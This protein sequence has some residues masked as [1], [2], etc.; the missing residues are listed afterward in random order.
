MEYQSLYRKYRPKNFDSV[1]GQEVVLKILKNAIDQSKISHAYLF[2]G[3]RGTG[4]TT[5]ARILA[6]AIN[7][8]F[9]NNGNCCEKCKPCEIAN[10]KEN[11]DILEIDAASNNGVNEIRELR[12]KINLVPNTLKYKVYII[13]EVHMLSREAFP[14]L[15]KTL[16]E[17]PKHAIFILATTELHEVPST[18]LSR[19]QLLEFKQ[20]SN[21]NLKKRLLEISTGEDINI[22][23]EALDEICKIVNGG[24]R[25][26]IGILEKA[27]LYA[28]DSITAEDI[29]KINGNI[30]ENSVK[31]LVNFINEENI[32]ALIN[33]VDE[34]HNSGIDLI[35][36]ANEIIHY[37]RDEI[38]KRKNTESNIL[39]NNIEELNDSINKMR[40]ST[41]PKPIFEIT[42][43]KLCGRNK[44][45]TEH[46]EE[47]T[48]ELPPIQPKKEYPQKND[49]HK[50]EEFKQID[51]PD[52]YKD[53]K[54][55]RVNNTLSAADKNIITE[56]REKWQL[57]RNEAFNTTYGAFARI[58][59]DDAKP[60]AASNEYLI[61]TFKIESLATQCNDAM[62][63]IE[64]LIQNILKA[65]YRIICLSDEEW[66]SCIE[67]YKQNK[68]KY[69]YIKE[70]T[71]D[72]TI[73]IEAPETEKNQEKTLKDKA[74]ELFGEI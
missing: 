6:K 7:C 46:Q 44:K 49:E 10:Q 32:E 25:D 37:I 67:D 53:I 33:K 72:K 34:Y 3:P 23:E 51:Q 73:D 68:E 45:I 2:A 29:R 70:E 28:N 1:V 26:A 57:L 52:K 54:K 8:E 24:L 5:I 17:P 13:D 12:N 22:E 18:I 14:A 58:L 38:F 65:S 48:N 62:E 40:I 20:I 30:S 71:E 11:I 69:I 42:L 43:L 31:E 35:R 16:E 9:P 27:T 64:D 36:L 4:K 66:K 21:T 74:K 59:F 50:I 56:I 39:S 41:N 60:V 55:I 63:K 61:M 47:I 19:C 15:L